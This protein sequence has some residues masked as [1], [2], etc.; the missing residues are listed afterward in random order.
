MTPQARRFCR[1]RS[2]RQPV[3]PSKQQTYRSRRRDAA[4]C[5]S[6]QE[7]AKVHSGQTQNPRGVPKRQLFLLFILQGSILKDLAPTLFDSYGQSTENMTLS[8]PSISMVHLNAD[9]QKLPLVVMTRFSL[10]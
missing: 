8:M 3:L 4:S 7:A 10:M 9:W 5:L 1:F 2:R 6:E